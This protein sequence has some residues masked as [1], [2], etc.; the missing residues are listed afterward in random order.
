M[1]IWK[2]GYMIIDNSINRE[3]KV[4]GIITVIKIV[5]M[6]VILVRSKRKS[7]SN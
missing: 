1:R 4:I 7:K 2:R 6:M 3:E 5:M